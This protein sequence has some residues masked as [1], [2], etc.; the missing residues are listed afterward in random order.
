MRRVGSVVLSDVLGQHNLALVV[1][2]DVLGQSRML[3]A[4]A[5]VA[6]FLA[7]AHAAVRVVRRPEPISIWRLASTH[8]RLDRDSRGDRADHDPAR[9]AR[10]LPARVLDEQLRAVIGDL[11]GTCSAVGIGLLG[12]RGGRVPDGERESAIAQL[13]RR[14]PEMG[15]AYVQLT[16]VLGGHLRRE[17]DRRSL[18]TGDTG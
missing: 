8:D 5:D 18:L 2:P 12:L 13:E 16:E 11:V 3:G 7:R 9:R 1:S 4:R 6:S 17:L 14:N 15:A 10:R